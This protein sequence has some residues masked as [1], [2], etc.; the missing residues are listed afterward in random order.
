MLEAIAKFVK[1]KMKDFKE[2]NINLMKEIIATFSCIAQ[3]CDAINKRTFQ[4]GMSFFIDKIG[5]VKMSVAIK[6]ML[7]FAAEKVSPKFISLQTIKYGSTAKAPK[8]IQESCVLLT[9]ICDDFGVSGIP[10]KESIDFAKIAAAHATP[11]VR[12]SAIKFF[13]ELFRHAGEGIRSFMDDI[14]ESTLKVIDAEL[15]SCT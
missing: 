15:K 3:N 12:Q 14:K 8:N 10:L 5:D 7:I 11:A 4:V 6:E 2:S 13:C 9:T 1:A